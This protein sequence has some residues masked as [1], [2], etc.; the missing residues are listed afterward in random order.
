MRTIGVMPV[1]SAAMQICVASCGEIAPCSMSMNSQSWS[2]AAA[3]MPVA[4]VRR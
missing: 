4:L 2:P 3:I 1:G